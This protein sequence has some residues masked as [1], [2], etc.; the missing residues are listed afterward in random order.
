MRKR[1]LGATALAVLVLAAC[2]D[3]EEAIEE[4]EEIEILPVDE[5]MAEF[6]ASEGYETYIG[7][8]ELH[9]IQ[10][11]DFT[12]DDIPEFVT[13]YE[14]EVEGKAYTYVSVFSRAETEEEVKWNLATEMYSE[15]PN[16]T[17][18][19]YGTFNEDEFVS[20]WAGGYTEGTGDDAKKVVQVYDL[21]GG[22]LTPLESIEGV[23][24]EDV[25]FD[26]ATETLTYVGEVTYTVRYEQGQLVVEK[27][28]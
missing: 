18:N 21:M 24:S 19:N 23:A 4:Q 28:Q 6:K 2:S 27:T 15:D 22:K 16:Y 13:S 5:Y 17:Y 12:K 9:F 11:V 10:P 8:N 14:A 7:E 26:V 20:L 1:F 25:T 3:K